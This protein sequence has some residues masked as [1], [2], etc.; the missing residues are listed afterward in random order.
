[1]ILGHSMALPL[2]KS[3]DRRCLRTDQLPRTDHI[4]AMSAQANN[5]AQLAKIGSSV[6]I[7]VSEIEKWPRGSQLAKFLT[8]SWKM[9]VRMPSV[10]LISLVVMI[11]RS[12]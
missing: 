4:E 11:A 6:V 2:K 7:I 9:S 12:S 5:L 8:R 10:V 1:M 3:L